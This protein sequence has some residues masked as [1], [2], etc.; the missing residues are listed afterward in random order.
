MSKFK[1]AFRAARKSGAKVF[2]FNGKSYN[3]KLKE[4]GG[5]SKTKSV[6]VPQSKPSGKTPTPK[7]RPKDGPEARSRPARSPKS[8]KTSNTGPSTRPKREAKSTKTKAPAVGIAKAGSPMARYAAKVK[9]QKANTRARG[10]GG[11]F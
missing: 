4:E 10:G 9:T 2:T 6:P 5:S 3:T 11:G 1:E 7:A 8:A